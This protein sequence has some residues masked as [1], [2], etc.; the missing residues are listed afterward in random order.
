MKTKLVA[1][2]VFLLLAAA[3]KEEKQEMPADD[4]KNAWLAPDM[5]D[6]NPKIIKGSTDTLVKNINYYLK[7]KGITASRE[8]KTKQSIFE[9]SLMINKEGNLDR[10]TIEKSDN[11]IVD[12]L[13]IATVKYWKLTPGVKKGENVN[14]I[15]PLN[16]LVG[17]NSNSKSITESEYPI[18]V[19]EM[20]EPI[21]GIK[22]I[23]EKIFYPEIAKRAGVEGKVYLIA[24]I[25]ENGVVAAVKIIKGI[26]AGCDEAAMDAV[27]NTKFKPGK[28]RGKPIK[29]QVTV[30]IVFKL[31]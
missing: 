14:S 9:Y 30:P 28:Q 15:F 23:Q 26:G 27:L 31:Q 20:P 1:I 17:E 4:Y 29:V 12:S 13:V 3:C 24:F 11:A 2:L 21:G 5:L 16:L 19:D 25:N 10:V 8:G 6:E 22:A 7:K 18:T